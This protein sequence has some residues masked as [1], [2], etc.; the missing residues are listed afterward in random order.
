MIFW[1]LAATDGHAKNFS[2]AHLPGS[3]YEST[4]LYDVLSAHPIIGAGAGRLPAQKVKL[5]MAVRGKNVHYLLNQI[6]RRHWIAE[7]QR[8][9]FSA[10]IVEKMIDELT[11]RTD[12]VIEEVSAQ[13]P[14]GFPM[15]VADAVFDGMRRLNTKLAQST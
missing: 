3:H 4:P 12:A 9:G 7:G 5:A 8:V 14:N 11:A 15:D 6:Q 1:L 10:A 13:L 2:I